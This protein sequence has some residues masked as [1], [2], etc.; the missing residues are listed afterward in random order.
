[1]ISAAASD[2]RVRE[3]TSLWHRSAAPQPGA[4]PRR[5]RGGGPAAPANHTPTP[6]PG[7]AAGQ[8]W[9]R[10]WAVS[11]NARRASCVWI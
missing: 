9:P 11:G 1:M 7:A 3:T 4:S 2:H 10:T 6:H 8:H 5:P